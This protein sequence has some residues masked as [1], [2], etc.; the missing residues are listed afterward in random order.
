M[1]R[2]RWLG[3]TATAAGMLLLA[4]LAAWPLLSETSPVTFVEP[5][6]AAV[7]PW[8]ALTILA[9]GVT[10]AIVG[11]H[12]LVDPRSGLH[13]AGT[14]LL[15]LLTAAAM[16]GWHFLAV[17]QFSEGQQ[18]GWY[19]DILNGRSAPPHQFRP[20]PYGF[21]RGLEHLTGEW[22]SACLLCR[23]FF[24]Y[25]FLWAAHQFGLRFLA[26]RRAWYV[27]AA[28][29]LLYPFSIAYYGGQLTDPLSHALFVLG[30]LYIVEDR[31]VALA[32]ALALGVA[33]KETALVLVPAY[34]LCHWRQ[35]IPAFWKSA[36]LAA[37]G[38]A[39]FLAC[40][41]PFGWRP[42]NRSLNG[43]D[44]LMIGTNLGIGEPLALTTVPLVMNYVHPLLFTL[45][46]LPFIARGWRLLDASLRVLCLVLVP[47]VLLSS[48]CFSWLYES[49]NYLPL[50]PLL[51]TAALRAY[52]LAPRNRQHLGSEPASSLT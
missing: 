31:V 14:S 28:M 43:L 49:R 6:R 40:R 11:L 42:S 1:T 45:P 29:V 41:I 39:A 12:L 47:T 25:L 16:T 50:V 26:P 18:R 15:L 27:V 13:T 8:L 34:F 21:T 3:D 23:W 33:A 24:T 36:F 48:L 38:A 35:G 51:A 32:A 52:D 2:R 4:V 20:L 5:A 9:L 7:A 22:H 46:F 17:D 44:A 30:M 10:V 19:L 37:A